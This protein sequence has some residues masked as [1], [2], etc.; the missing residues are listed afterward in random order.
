MEDRYVYGKSKG[1]ENNLL[2][3]SFSFAE[4]LSVVKQVS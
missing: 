1:L 4:V 2:S 3:F